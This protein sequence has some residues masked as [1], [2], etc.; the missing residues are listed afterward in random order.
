[1]SLRRAFVESLPTVSTTKP[2]GTVTE[3]LRADVQRLP[4]RRPMLRKMEAVD[5]RQ[6]TKSRSRHDALHLS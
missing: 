3:S 5:A 4:W 2:E 6:M 1:M